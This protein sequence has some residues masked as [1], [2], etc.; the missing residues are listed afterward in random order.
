MSMLATCL[1]WR[2]VNVGDISMLAT[3]DSD[4]E[5]TLALT[6]I[7]MSPTSS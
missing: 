7:T 3:D 4:G 6:N 1:C 2:H 5:S